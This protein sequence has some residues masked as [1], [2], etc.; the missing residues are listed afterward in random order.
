MAVCAAVQ[1]AIYLRQLLS[2]LG[3]K[4]DEPTVVFEDNQ[5]CTALAENPVHHKRTKHTDTRYHFTRERVESG[6]VK[7]VYVPTKDQ[8][9][10]L[11]TKPVGGV[12]LEQLRGKLLGYE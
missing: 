2:D 4:Q 12:R 8:L 9:A 11:L 5:G 6:E 1:E 3:H 7:L 10:D